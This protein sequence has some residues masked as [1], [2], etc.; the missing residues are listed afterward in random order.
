MGAWV[1]VAV[2]AGVAVAT[3]VGV[4]DPLRIGVGLLGTGRPETGCAGAADP[5]QP[6]SVDA[7]AKA[8]KTA[9]F[10]AILPHGESDRVR[11]AEGIERLVAR[12]PCAQPGANFLGVRALFELGRSGGMYVAKRKREAI[13]KGELACV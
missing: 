12:T 4:G 5:P 13:L 10:I 1:G 11:L 9:C 3:A 8:K 6:A 2:A 7:R